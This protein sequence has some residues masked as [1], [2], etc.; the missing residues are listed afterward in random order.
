MKPPFKKNKQSHQ[1]IYT[2]HAITYTTYSK[3]MKQIA[4]PSPHFMSMKKTINLYRTSQTTNLKPSALPISTNAKLKKT[5]SPHPQFKKAQ[6]LTHT[7]APYH[8]PR[9]KNINQYNIT[10]KKQHKQRLAIIFASPIISSL[11][12]LA[13]YPP[14]AVVNLMQAQ[15]NT[16]MID[17]WKIQYNQPNG[18]YHGMYPFGLAKFKSRIFGLTVSTCLINNNPS[19]TSI[20][21]AAFAG[22]SAETLITNRDLAK[23]RYLVIQNTSSINLK[24]LQAS[25]RFMFATHLIKNFATLGVCQN[26]YHFT[27]DEI[28]ESS[29][30]S[31]NSTRGILTGLSMMLLQIFGASHLDTAMTLQLK[32]KI[33]NPQSNVSALNLI[34][35]VFKQPFSANIAVSLTRAGIFGI[36]YAGTFTCIGS[37]KN[38][39]DTRH[40]EDYN[41][42]KPST[43]N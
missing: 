28:I 7:K 36:G 18:I 11:D 31:P 6:H 22:A 33:Q 3:L 27:P 2:K 42:P 39:I 15:K 38:Y 43:G 37:I 4:M 40:Q 14:F 5:Q 8:E 35:R 1:N 26:V 41:S 10:L 34:S 30:Y 13:L 16:R 17:A 25:S 24:L 23:Q 32:E 12:C 20:I 19:F 9:T 21:F 29:P